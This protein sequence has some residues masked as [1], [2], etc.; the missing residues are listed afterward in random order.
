MRL[1]ELS[2]VRIILE[3][4]RGRV[5]IA[6]SLVFTYNPKSNWVFVLPA[7]SILGVPHDQ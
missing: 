5:N 3:I 6:F 2:E 1:R 7:R 4:A